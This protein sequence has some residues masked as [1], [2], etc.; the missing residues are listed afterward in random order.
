[1]G[2]EQL[3]VSSDQ[4]LVSSTRSLKFMACYWF[5]VTALAAQRGTTKVVTTNLLWTSVKLYESLSLSVSQS[6]S[7]PPFS[8]QLPTASLP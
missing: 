6:P 1:M 7:P 5:V 2:S 8:N 3:A 4:S